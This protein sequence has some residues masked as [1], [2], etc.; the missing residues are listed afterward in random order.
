MNKVCK[1]ACSHILS[2]QRCKTK[3]FFRLECVHVCQKLSRWSENLS[4]AVQ[5]W[6]V[7]ASKFCKQAGIK[8]HRI[9]SHPVWSCF[10]M[11]CREAI[12]LLRWSDHSWQ[13]PSELAGERP[14][15]PWI[16]RFSRLLLYLQT[17]AYASAPASAS[18]QKEHSVQ[19]AAST[20]VAYISKET[21]GQIPSGLNRK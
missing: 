4:A 20:Q 5:S 11:T 6:T 10:T 8:T 13:N 2:L 18:P 9:E 21:W 12:Y 3:P 19:K 17:D 7:K 16:R 15:S 1:C 14:W